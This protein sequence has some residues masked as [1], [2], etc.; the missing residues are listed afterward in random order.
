MYKQSHN[1]KG[2]LS[3]NEDMWIA[4]R[5]GEGLNEILD[6]FY[7]KVYQDEKLKGF[8]INVTKRRAIEKQFSF[9]QSIFTGTK[10]YFG[11]HP[12]KAHSWM[13]ITDELF[14]YRE[15]IIKECLV[16]YGLSEDL[17]QRWI[18]VDDI[19]R[20]V[21][22]KSK[23][24]DIKIG[25]TIRPSEGYVIEKLDIDTVCDTCFAE[26]KAFTEVK[27]HIRKGEVLCN[28]CAKEIDI[29]VYMQNNGNYVVV[30]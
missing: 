26:V 27:C 10:C 23:P 11:E 9:L 17:I 5:H 14:T 24:N 21:I 19:F 18:D 6:N 25:N 15:N 3:P 13:V 12:K 7:T 1:R 29:R 4:L 30:E 16:E 20:K 22:V 8:F 2:K 28:K